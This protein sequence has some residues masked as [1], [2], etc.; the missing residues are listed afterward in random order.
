MDFF[1]KGHCKRDCN[2]C[3]YCDKFA[4]KAITYLVPIEKHEE[5]MTSLRDARNMM[6]KGELF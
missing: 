2:E 4:E 3:N 6:I 1:H 5:A